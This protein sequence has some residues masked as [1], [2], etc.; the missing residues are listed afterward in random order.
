[1]KIT[2]APAPAYFSLD[3]SDL[4]TLIGAGPDAISDVKVDSMG[5]VVI[6]IESDKVEDVKKS[7][8]DKFH[9]PLPVDMYREAWIDRVNRVYGDNTCKTSAIKEIRAITNC[10]IV[11]GKN[12]VEHW[13][14][15]DG[16]FT[17]YPGPTPF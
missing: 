14:T 1:M 13:F 5:F 12:W 17:P 10:G 4:Q 11:E 16:T 9:P 3:W 7:I 8:E 2:Q 6:K 15:R